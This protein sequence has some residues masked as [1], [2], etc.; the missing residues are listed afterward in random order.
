MP[1]Q[2]PLFVLIG[3]LVVTYDPAHIVNG[4]P[5]PWCVADAPG[6]AAWFG[7]ETEIERW[8]ARCQK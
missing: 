3:G 5:A 6:G 4:Y 7:T 2:A 8:R 1:E